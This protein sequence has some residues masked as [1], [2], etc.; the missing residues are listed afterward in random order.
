MKLI[1]VFFCYVQPLS[2]TTV[3]NFNTL[4]GLHQWSWQYV[5]ARIQKLVSYMHVCQ[6][7]I[8]VHTYIRTLSVCYT[9]VSSGVRMYVLHVYACMHVYE[10]MHVYACICTYMHVY[11]YMNVCTYMHV[12]ARINICWRIYVHIRANTCNTYIRTLQF[13]YVKHTDSV[14]MYVC[15]HIYVWHTCIYVN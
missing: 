3:P 11:P 5:C 4:T 15:A 10:R 14:R 6:T 8:R 13:T 1:R 2:L 9:Y 12:Y 7:Y